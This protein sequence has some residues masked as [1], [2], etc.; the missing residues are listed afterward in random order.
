MTREARSARSRGAGRGLIL[1]SRRARRHENGWRSVPLAKTLSAVERYFLAAGL[2][3]QFA[4]IGRRAGR[5]RRA[6]LMSISPAG[7]SKDRLSY[8]KGLS[9]G[10]AL[11]SACFEFFERQCAEMRPDDR[12]VEAAYDEVADVAVDPRLFGLAAGAA[13]DPAGT[14]RW[15]RGH[16]LTRGAPVLVPAGLAYFP[17]LVRPGEARLAW[18]DSNGLASGNNLEEAVLHGLLE[19]IERDAVMI[20]EYNELPIIGLDPAGLPGS[21]RPTVERLAEAGFQTAFFAGRSDLPIPFIAAFL[22]RREKPSD[23]SVGF[24]LD[25]DPGVALERALTEAIQVLPPSMNHAGWLRSGSPRRYAGGPRTRMRFEEMTGLAADDLKISVETCV[26]I[27]RGI[28]SE[29]V[30][31]DLSRPDV[32][33]PAVRVLAT[34][35]Q[36][37]LRKTD[38]RFSPR[39]FEVP[40]SLGLR[41]RPRRPAS[42]KLW[43]LCGYR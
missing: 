34:R 7:K 17:Y 30:V 28:G 8:G 18:T 35:L 19:V 32:P 31:V 25:L 42:V 23:C 38:R 3:A 21:C 4:M 27:L 29:V 10:Q 26:K 5:V 13:F 39:F 1:R 9:A 24:G 16:S 41:K 22:R 15:V 40:V 11:A 12:V 6:L 20:S 33:F 14:T 37:V 36:P 43:P 2:E